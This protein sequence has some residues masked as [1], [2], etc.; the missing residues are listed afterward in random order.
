[1]LVE[2][3]K[4]KVKCIPRRQLT[5]AWKTLS[6]KPLPKVKALELSDEDFD[7]ILLHRHC[8]EDDFREIEEWGRVLST[9]GTDAC[10]FNGDEDDNSDYVIL[11]RENPYHSMEEI[12]VHELSH[13]ARGDL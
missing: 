1:M 2:G 5:A 11:V 13:I 6:D 10:V 9:S 4:M 8:I 12:I 7:H 3:I